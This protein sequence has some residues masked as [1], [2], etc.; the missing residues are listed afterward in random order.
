MMKQLPLVLLLALTDCSCY[1]RPGAAGRTSTNVQI[2]IAAD[3]W[4]RQVSFHKRADHAELVLDGIKFLLFED[5]R[6]ELDW[7]AI[8]V[9]GFG[10]EGNLDYKTNKADALSPLTVEG[11]LVEVKD[12]QLTWGDQALGSIEPGDEVRVA[13]KGVMRP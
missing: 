13:A 5:A 4:A 8:G 10:A 3:G 6:Y 12:G 2:D 9:E 11:R 1:E 7:K